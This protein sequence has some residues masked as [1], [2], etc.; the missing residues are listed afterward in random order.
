MHDDALA[1]ADHRPT[2]SRRR[3]LAAA[4]VSTLGAVAGARLASAAPSDVV[5]SELNDAGRALQ[6][7]HRVPPPTTTTTTTT[8]PP[9]ERP[10]DGVIPFPI[11]VGPGDRCFVHDNFGDCR[12][13]GCSRSHEGVDIMADRGLPVRAVADGVLTKRYVDSGACGGAGNG[14]TLYDEANDVTY[15]FFHLDRHAEGLEKGD[16]VVTGQIIGYVGE[17]GTSGVCNPYDNYHLHFEYRPGNVAQDS[18]DLLDRDPEVTF[19]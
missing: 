11:V 18:Y 13:S 6:P 7:A 15:K 16:A 9:L 3:F 4:G 17:T 19:G 8:V 5:A 10:P 12:G 2:F 1:P 14:W